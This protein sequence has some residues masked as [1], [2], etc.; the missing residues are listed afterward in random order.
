MKQFDYD[1]E[2]L[3]REYMQNVTADPTAIED[4][5]S[6]KR[7]SANRGARI[8]HSTGKMIGITAAA[9]AVAICAGIGFS[10]LN[11][12]DDS[13]IKSAATTSQN[14]SAITPAKQ[15]TQSFKLEATS[16]T[17]APLGARTILTL[18]ATD[19]KGREI[20]QKYGS[21]DVAK[22]RIWLGGNESTQ[23]PEIIDST[24]FHHEWH[25]DCR[26]A[27]VRDDQMTFIYDTYLL[28]E[29]ANEAMPFTV[30]VFCPDENKQPTA[31]QIA[32]GEQGNLSIIASAKLSYKVNAAEQVFTSANGEV[33]RVSDFYFY[34]NHDDK[35]NLSNLLFDMKFN[36][37]NST[38]R[39]FVKQ[40]L[41]HLDQFG[42]DTLCI[43]GGYI[44]DEYKLL[45]FFNDSINSD[46]VTSIIYD[47]IT[48]N[49]VEEVNVEQ[50][51]FKS[52]MTEMFASDHSLRVNVKL[53]A[54][55]DDAKKLLALHANEMAS[56]GKTR[57]EAAP[58]NLDELPKIGSSSS[59][60]HVINGDTLTTTVTLN[61]VNSSDTFKD[62]TKFDIV[63][64]CTEK[65]GTDC[66]FIPADRRLTVTVKKNVPER[67]FK[68]AS[69]K[70]LWLTDYQFN[71]TMDASKLV[72]NTLSEYQ[73]NFDDEYNPTKTQTSIPSLA[74]GGARSDKGDPNTNVWFIDKIDSSR[75][76]SITYGGEVFTAQ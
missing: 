30:N 35:N 18:T 37:A 9:A 14:V 32:N 67:V 26:V 24:G 64:T 52:E 38:Q 70:T 50:A 12:N 3:Y 75:V 15:I 44:N 56:N 5:L 31:D 69:G 68:S 19:E 73:I 34:T 63:F 72:G 39:S 22:N 25:D 42:T 53:T 65:D 17:A 58:I 54:Q 57:I 66:R 71:C 76:K 47:G 60:T 6:G 28:C 1:A 33:F 43:G 45:H 8:K 46:E 36:F 29:A 40:E 11:A 16:M 10:A 27:K 55:N 49:K 20:I 59:S 51:K 62:G 48:F 61:R 74:D 13:G 4:I 2:H 21:E 23:R 41:S 7:K